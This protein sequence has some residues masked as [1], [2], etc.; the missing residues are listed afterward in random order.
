MSDRIDQLFEEVSA[1]LGEDVLSDTFNDENIP[2]VMSID[3]RIK[4]LEEYALKVIDVPGF[5]PSKDYIRFRKI[6]LLRLNRVHS[7]LVDVIKDKRRYTAAL[8]KRISTG[9]RD[10]KKWVRD[11]NEAVQ[12]ALSGKPVALCAVENRISDY[13]RGVVEVFYDDDRD[14]SKGIVF[15]WGTQIAD[16]KGPISNVID[17]L[18]RLHTDTTAGLTVQSSSKEGMEEYEDQGREDG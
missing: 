11:V 13:S 4:I 8:K 7:L 3:G 12:I 16:C 17:I 14:L 6:R 15:V 9:E 10:P 1:M 2:S 5:D 18:E